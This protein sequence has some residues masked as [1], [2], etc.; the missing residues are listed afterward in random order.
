MSTTPYNLSAILSMLW[1][2]PIS[3]NTN[4][5]KIFLSELSLFN[6][7]KSNT[8]LINPDFVSIVLYQQDNIFEYGRQFLKMFLIYYNC[9]LSKKNNEV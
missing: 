6:S 8:S 4:E 2:K 9:M 7:N 1:H 3:S 5:Y